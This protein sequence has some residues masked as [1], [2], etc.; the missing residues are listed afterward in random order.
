MSFD[1]RFATPGD[2]PTILHLIRLLAEHEHEPEAVAVTI[3][4]LR[5][6]LGEAHPPFEC[7]IA[8]DDRRPIGFALFF[9]NYSTWR[10]RPG[11][12][13]EDLFVVEEYRGRGVGAAL[14]GRLRQI[15]AERGWGRMEWAVLNWN[16][17]AQNF[18]RGH[19]ARPLE[20]WTLW[21]IDGV[22]LAIQPP[23]S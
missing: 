7:L 3:A 19:G 20:D 8:E 23:E 13:L 6:Q 14:M 11:L 4:E 16:T 22:S 2:A 17:A 18:Y 10:G 9:R 5:A 1:I 15:V 12:F 21:R